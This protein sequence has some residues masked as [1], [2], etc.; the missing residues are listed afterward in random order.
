MTKSL[1][2][3]LYLMKRLLFLILAT[4]LIFGCQTNQTAKEEKAPEVNY[5]PENQKDGVFIHISHGAEDAHR[6]AMGLKMA[7]LMSED[8]DVLV[9]FDINGIDVVT[10]DT[11]DIKMNTFPSSREALK[12]LLTN[13]IS[14]YACPG[15]MK[16]KGVTADDLLEGIKVANKDAFFDFTKGRILTLDY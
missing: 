6:V 11:P 8:K 2:L 13:N 7:T 12:E 3:I 10:K 4:M 14:V 5:P 9:Y 1:I 15:C 16:A